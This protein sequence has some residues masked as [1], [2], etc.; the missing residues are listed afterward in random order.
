MNGMKR[1]NGL[2]LGNEPARLVGVHC[3]TREEQ[4]ILFR[5]NEEAEPKWKWW[6]VVDVSGGD[7]KWGNNGN[8]T[9][10]YFLGLQN[11]YGW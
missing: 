4:R 10:F 5:K 11:H 6:P 8:S 7:S 3:V 1:Q 2:K 9:D